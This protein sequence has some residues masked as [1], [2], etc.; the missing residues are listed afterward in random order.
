VA[1]L[2]A[3]HLDLETAAVEFGKGQDRRGL[4]HAS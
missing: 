2:L 3:G 4:C 1:A